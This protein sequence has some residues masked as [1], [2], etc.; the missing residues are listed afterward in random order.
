MSATR[1]NRLLTLAAVAVALAAIFVLESRPSESVLCPFRWAT[2]LPCPFCGMTRG[3]AALLH[4]RI[5]EAIEHHPF[6]PL[7]LAGILATA[8]GRVPP[9]FMWKW[10][11]VG[12]GVFG[13]VRMLVAAL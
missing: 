4:G 8:A 1:S 11:A 13:G 10:L 12:L 7:A 3:L 5:V 6:S 2:S 9:P